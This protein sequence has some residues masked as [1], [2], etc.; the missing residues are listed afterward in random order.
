MAIFFVYVKYLPLVQSSSMILS[1]IDYNNII[2]IN[3]INI[4][5]I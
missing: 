5:M 4:I 3:I 1:W 2:R